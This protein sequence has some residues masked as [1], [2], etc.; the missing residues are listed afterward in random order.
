MPKVTVNGKAKSF[1]YT[2]AGIKQAKNVAKSGKGTLTM[3]KM[4]KKKQMPSSDG[5]YMG[6]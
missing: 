2:K 3:T 1:P 4:P 5:V 6:K